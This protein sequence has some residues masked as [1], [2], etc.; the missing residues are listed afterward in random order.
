MTRISERNF[1]PNFSPKVEFLKLFQFFS[2]KS[3]FKSHEYNNFYDYSLLQLLDYFFDQWKL[4]GS[5]TTLEEMMCF[6]KLRACDV[7]DSMSEDRLLDY[8]QFI[9][10]ALFFLST[11]RIYPFYISNF[12]SI[13]NSILHHSKLLLKKLNAEVKKIEDEYVVLYKNDAAAV[14]STQQP[15]LA[16]SIEEYLA[17]SNRDDLQR[18]AE[19]LCSLAKALEPQEQRLSKNG[20]QQLCSD[21]TFLLNKT[22]IRHALNPNDRIDSQFLEMD[23]S[24]RI[25]WYDRAFKT[26][27]ACM[28]VL[29]YLEFKD[30]IKDIKRNG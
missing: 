14:V 12:D 30:E 11:I 24:E 20:F 3:A 4:R 16:P 21:A 22:G 5:F 18:K 9:F 23:D 19:V 13:Q 28:A 6:F 10:N 7:S 27:L 2:D 8:I 17:I 15:E 1:F 29:P 25:R 26:V